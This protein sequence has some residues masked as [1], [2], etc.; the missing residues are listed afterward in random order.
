MQPTASNGP[1]VEIF[2]GPHCSY[3]SR[4]KA[5]LGRKGL[6]YREIDISSAQNFEEMANRLP[7]M[8]S[9]PQ[10][11]IG[12]KHIGGC[13]DLELLDASGELDHLVGKRQDVLS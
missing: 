7:R 8:R 10:I 9:I 2:T 5:L 12:G 4:A 1:L 6:A 13:E 3:C 11:F